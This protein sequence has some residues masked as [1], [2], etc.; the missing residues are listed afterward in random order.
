MKVVAKPAIFIDPTASN[1]LSRHQPSADTCNASAATVTN[2]TPAQ[3]FDPTRAREIAKFGRP[4][5]SSTGLP[6]YSNTVLQT[7]SSSATPQATRRCKTHHSN[8]TI[9]DTSSQEVLTEFGRG[10]SRIQPSHPSYKKFAHGNRHT[11]HKRCT[12][13]SAGQ[14]HWTAKFIFAQEAC[15]RLGK[16][17]P[18]TFTRAVQRMYRQAR[19][20]FTPCWMA[21]FYG[22]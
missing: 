9:Q 7:Q 6:R 13:T 20:H 17:R 16:R 21:L 10:G 11:Q 14:T 19:Y 2:T 15:H 5:L 4:P 18:R 8:T 12:R 3:S 22:P 1:L